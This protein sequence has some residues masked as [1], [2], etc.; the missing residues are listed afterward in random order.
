MEQAR[1]VAVKGV[2]SEPSEKEVS[3]LKNAVKLLSMTWPLLLGNTLEWY[4]FGVYGYVETEI[5][6]NFFGDSAIGGWMGY[7]ITFAARPIGGILLGWIA[8]NWGRKLS[9]NLSLAGMIV[10]TVGQG[11]LPGKYWGSRFQT[12]GLILLV[13]TRA[14]QGISAGGEIGAISCYLME[15]SPIKTLGMAVCMISVGSQVAWAFASFFL[16]FLN[17]TIGADAMLVWGWRV[18]FVISIFPGLL[19]LWGRNML[20][21][22]DIFLSETTASANTDGCDLDAEAASTTT[23]CSKHRSDKTRTGFIILLTK[24]LPNLLISFGATVGV[25]TM[26]FVPPFWTLQAILDAHIGP[27]AS[28]WVGNSAQIVGLAIT[29]VAGLLADKMGVAW[30]ILIGAAFF[31]SSG[32]PVYTWLTFHSSDLLSA[33]VCIGF[34]Y[35]L[36]QGFSGAVIYLFVAEL[37]PAKL[38][39][40]GIALSYNIAVSYVGGFGSMICQALLPVSYHVAP[41]MWFS[42]TGLVSLLTVVVAI[43]L[44]R[45]GFVKL[46]HRRTTPYFGRAE[47]R[48]DDGDVVC[49]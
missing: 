40:Q 22:S 15:V 27:A 39:C 16:A 12:L 10:G 37:F 30:T 2:P 31:A 49:H 45:R 38:R 48:E 34:F 6:A 29:P 19:A 32:L 1:D 36:A 14:L 17:S 47:P 24:Y 41:G 8:D 44:E 11:L 25:A 23:E 5:A 35:G 43:A 21:E 20:Q 4:E 28:L 3:Y 26:W 9:V 42:A 46:T 33:Y 18:P 13:I 7:A